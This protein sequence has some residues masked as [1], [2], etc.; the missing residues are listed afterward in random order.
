MDKKVYTNV[1]FEN[2]DHEKDYAGVLA[3]FDAHFE[4]KK[5]K[6][7]NLYMKKFDG[8]TQGPEIL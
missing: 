4:R 5:K 2:E 8:M 6:V 7:T 1:E 3:K